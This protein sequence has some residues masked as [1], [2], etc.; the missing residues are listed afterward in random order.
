MSGRYVFHDVASSTRKSMQG[1][2]RRDTTPELAV[3]RL[4]HRSGARYRV[5]FPITTPERRVRVDVAFP[6]RRLAVFI[7]GCYWHGCPVHATTPSRNQDYWV[8][9]IA[10]NRQRDELQ[11]ELLRRAGWVVLRIWE[12]E[13]PTD[14]A[15]RILDALAAI[16]RYQI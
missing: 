13:D 12:H 7:D 14:A 15:A 2:S 9:K 16:R 6:R 1:N 8:R 4:L 3:R 5:D 10:E 11:G